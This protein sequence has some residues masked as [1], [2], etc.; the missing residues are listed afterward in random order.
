MTIPKGVKRFRLTPKVL[1][2][3]HG[4]LANVRVR[5]MIEPILIEARD[6]T[7][8][9]CALMIREGA[10]MICLSRSNSAT[11]GSVSLDIG[12]RMPLH[13]SPSGR[14][15]LASLPDPELSAYLSKANLVRR[16]PKT[17]VKKSELRKEILRVRNNGFALTLDEI[18]VG[19]FS[20]AVAVVPGST[21]VIG[22]VTCIG[23]AARVKTQKARDKVVSVLNDA[24]AQ[25]GKLLPDDYDFFPD[26]G[27]PGR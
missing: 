2:L 21:K 13:V 27:T 11:F 15:M 25:I 6:Q 20:I 24:A 7:E 22:G 19:V 8:E 5:D 14:V 26:R 9:S 3:G 12:T 23:N 10:D 16:T 4:Y 1:D 17:I 18:S